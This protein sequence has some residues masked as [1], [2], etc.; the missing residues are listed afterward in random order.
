M[1]YRV[2]TLSAKYGLPPGIA[3]AGFETDRLPESAADRLGPVARASGA[4]YAG[5]RS[6]TCVGAAGERIDLIEAG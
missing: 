2:V 6:G 3:R 1:H 4:S 5:R